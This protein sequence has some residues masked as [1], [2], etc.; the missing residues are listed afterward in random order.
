LEYQS[1]E[2]LR[3]KEGKQARIWFLQPRLHIT[4]TP[5]FISEKIGSDVAGLELLKACLD[6]ETTSYNPPD[7]AP[8]FLLLP[9][10]SIRPDEI[11]SVRPLIAA[12]RPNTVFVS[13]C[14]QL[15]EQQAREIEPGSVLWDG[16]SH[17][18]FTNCALVGVG[19]SDRLF[20]Q[21][22]IVPSQWER[23]AHWPGNKIRCFLG[24]FVLFV[25]VICSDL[26]ARPADQ[27]TLA[28]MIIELKRDVRTLNLVIWLQHNPDPRS[29]EFHQSL[30]SLAEFAP[31]VLVVS[32]RKDRPHRL[33]N[34]AVSGAIVPQHA[35]PTSFQ[36][37]DASFRYVEPLMDDAYQTPMSRLVL[38]RYDVD[39]YRAMTVLAAS[40]RP[41]DKTA[42]GALFEYSDPYQYRSGRLE[43]SRDHT[44]LEDILTPTIQ[45]AC[46]QAPDLASE[47]NRVAQQLVALGT[48]NLL[49]FLDVAILPI[50]QPGER[51]HAAGDKHA[52]GDFRCRCWP[53]RCCIDSLA[54]E[55][56]AQES[57]GLVM[58]AAGA[59]LKCGIDAH[60][61]YNLDRRTNFRAKIGAQ[62]LA[63]A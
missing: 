32:S 46:Q 34:F 9:E 53:H 40:I 18:K 1:L 7:E 31:T 3:W 38:L 58:T 27:T 54:H 55:V 19:G 44:H 5:P 43:P 56:Q 45:M 25:V 20:L 62:E 2:G 41:T 57:L 15:T 26:L 30:A 60:P 17:G 37:L 39:A 23:E 13:G 22:K 36:N 10:F 52:D 50:P 24:E 49:G 4:T 28:D 47:I 51:R 6:E 48:K 35:L 14:G 61:N 42:K 21:P 8:A 16:P 59:L 29:K 11:A 12:A 33:K 63:S